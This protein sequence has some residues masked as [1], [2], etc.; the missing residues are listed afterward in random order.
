MY[1]NCHYTKCVLIFRENR[2]SNKNVKEGLGE[3]FKV[4]VFT[5]A[6][7]KGA[8]IKQLQILPNVLKCYP[9]G[10]VNMKKPFY[11]SFIKQKQ[12]N[13]I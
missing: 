1:T 5:K 3:I 7:V 2:V 12:Q 8:Y 4:W 10:C 13:T 11:T 6:L 9:L